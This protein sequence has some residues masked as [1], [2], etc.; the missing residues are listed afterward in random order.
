MVYG[1]GKGRFS[2]DSFGSCREGGSIT[3]ASDG[4]KVL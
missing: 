3:L 2:L 1:K 4:D